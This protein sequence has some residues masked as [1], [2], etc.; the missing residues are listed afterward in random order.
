MHILGL[1]ISSQNMVN[2][3]PLTTA[4]DEDEIMIGTRSMRGKGFL[5]YLSYQIFSRTYGTDAGL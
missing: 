4:V 2:D 5:Y 3:D 1:A